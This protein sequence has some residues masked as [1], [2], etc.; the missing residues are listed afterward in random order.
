MV[1]GG[2]SAHLEPVK[3]LRKVNQK[4]RFDIFFIANAKSQAGTGLILAY[5]LVVIALFHRKRKGKERKGTYS[6]V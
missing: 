5:L 1:S 4:K 6:S 2:L 3:V